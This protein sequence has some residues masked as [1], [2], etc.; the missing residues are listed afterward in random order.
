MTPDSKG[1]YVLLEWIS[2]FRSFGES[3]RLGAVVDCDS[4]PVDAPT[5]NRGGGDVANLFRDFIQTAGCVGFGTCGS[6]V[7]CISP[8]GESF[9]NGETHD[10]P[11]EFE[12]DETYGAKWWGY[13]QQTMTDLLWQRRIALQHRNLCPLE[14]GRWQLPG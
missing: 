8:N 11:D 6:R 1:D 13:V 4:A 9:I 12:A 10:F 14:N 5:T 3:G 7:V 2:D